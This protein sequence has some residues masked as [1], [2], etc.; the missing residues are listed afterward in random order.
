MI[1]NLVYR[2]RQEVDTIFLILNHR[3]QCIVAAVQFKFSV[4]SDNGKRKRQKMRN[5]DAQPTLNV[6]ATN[7]LE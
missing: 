1:F 7:K 2:R 5:L 4:D 6:R 3:R